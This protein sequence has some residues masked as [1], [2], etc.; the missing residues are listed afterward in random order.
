MIGRVVGH[1]LEDFLAPRPRVLLPR[2]DPVLLV[3]WKTPAG[4]H[5]MVQ[6]IQIELESVHRSM[7]EIIDFCVRQS[8]LVSRLISSLGAA[9]GA[10]THRAH[11]LPPEPLSQAPGRSAQMSST[12]VIR[13]SSVLTRLPIRPRSAAD[14]RVRR[15]RRP[16]AFLAYSNISKIF[17]S[18]PRSTPNAPD[19]RKTPPPTSPR[20]LSAPDSSHRSPSSTN[21]SPAQ[22]RD[23]L[24]VSL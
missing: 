20:A 19:R 10:V 22:Y 7:R 12:R 24:R 11:R 5:I 13:P 18:R 8:A 23:P 21:S 16:R 17:P 3:R 1:A 14:P 4:A 15:R 2:L 9:H 6:S